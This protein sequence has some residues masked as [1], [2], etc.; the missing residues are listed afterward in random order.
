MPV[1]GEAR[2]GRVNTKAVRKVVGRFEWRVAAERLKSTGQQQRVSVVE[3]ELLRVVVQG[4]I[5]EPQYGA[6]LDFVESLLSGDVQWS[7]DWDGTV[8]YR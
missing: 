4:R 6:A 5:L 1:E 2:Q 8:P 3:L 7:A